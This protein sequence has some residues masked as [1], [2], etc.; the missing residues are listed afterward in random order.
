VWKLSVCSLERPWGPRGVRSQR[1][2]AGSFQ[3]RSVEKPYDKRSKGEPCC[4]ACRYVASEAERARHSKLQSHK[5]GSEFAGIGDVGEGRREVLASYAMRHSLRIRG[6]DA[7]APLDVSL[8]PRSQIVLR[9]TRPQK[10]PLQPCNPSYDASAALNVH[11][12]H[13]RG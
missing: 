12:V 3:G 13:R 9:Q 5:P 6:R 2:R 10:I 11:P 7:Q 4:E 8:L 1:K